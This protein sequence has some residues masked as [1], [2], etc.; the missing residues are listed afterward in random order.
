VPAPQR[1]A[2]IED[3]IWNPAQVQAQAEGASLAGLMRAAVQRYATGELT[4]Q[5]EPAS[6][7]APKLTSH[8]EPASQGTA[9]II[10]TIGHGEPASGTLCMGPGCFG[11]DTRKYGL[12]KL[13]LCTACAAALQGETY[14]REPPPSAVR[15]IHRGAA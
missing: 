14:K 3:E 1:T 15:A 7:P 8:L 11:R 12:R 10:T 4:S 2:R 9:A 13:P 6:Q 5:A